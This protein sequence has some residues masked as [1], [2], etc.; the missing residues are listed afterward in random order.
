MSTATLGDLALV[1]GKAELVGGRIIRYI[2]SGD[3]PSETDG[4]DFILS[5]YKKKF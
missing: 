3:V 4:R 5:F 2:P 1:E